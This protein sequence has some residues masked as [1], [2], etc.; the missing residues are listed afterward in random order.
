M[1]VIK[2]VLEDHTL[3][4]A[5]KV[6]FAILYCRREG[7]HCKLSAQELAQAV[8]LEL[9]ALRESLQHLEQERFIKI[10]EGC[11]IIDATSFLACAVL[12]EDLKHKE[13]DVPRP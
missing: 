1:D 9:D 7:I 4:P 12:G 3:G 2:E 13:P 10:E 8:G 6:L 11:E 5:E